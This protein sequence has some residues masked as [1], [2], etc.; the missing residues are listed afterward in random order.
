MKYTVRIRQMDEPDIVAV[1]ALHIHTLPTV[2]ARIGNP[3]ISI[4]YAQLLCDQSLH[5]TLIAT[6]GS[7]V[8]GVITATVNVHKTHHQL[9]PILFRPSVVLSICLAVL[10]GRVTISELVDRISTERQ[11][12]LQF[13]HTYATILTF[14]VDTPHQRQGI[15]K[16][17]LSALQKQLPRRTKLFVDTEISNT[18]AQKWY[19]VHGF[20]AIKTIGNSVIFSQR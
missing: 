19:E 13:P 10:R 8:I 9:Q 5:K 12:R 18:H 7:Q 20:L 3:Y 16:R 1:S 17:L 14:F 15:G 2:I 4:L 11:I 6:K